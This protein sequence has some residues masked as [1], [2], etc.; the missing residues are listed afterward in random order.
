MTFFSTH[1]FRKFCLLAGAV[2]LSLYASG[3]GNL[4]F[5][6]LGTQDGLSHSWAKCVT[7][8]S[9]G[10]LWVGTINGLNR[11]D[12]RSFK[13]FKND[14]ASDLTLS[15]NFIQVV[16]EDSKGNL[17]VGTYSGGINKFDRTT[18]SFIHFRSMPK[19]SNSLSDDRI[20]AIYE[21]SNGHLWVGTEKG[22]DR[23]NYKGNHF[24][25]FYLNGEK[26]T[27]SLKGP[28]LAIGE[29]QSGAI[30]AGTDHGLYRIDLTS[31]TITEYNSQENGGLPVDHITS[32]YKD[33]TGQLW[34]GTL[35]GG[36]S[37]YLPAS[38]EFASYSF[39]EKSE[40]G[41][42]HNSVLCISGDHKGQLIIGTEG[43]GI[44]LMNIHSK[45]VQV[46]SPDPEDAFS[47]NSN[48]IHSLFYDSTTQITWVGT[49]HGGVNYFSKLSKPFIHY[50]AGKNELNNNNVLCIREANGRLYVGTDGGGVNIMD[51]RTKK[52]EYLRQD[53]TGNK[54]I[55]S[56]A[57]LSLLIDQ[58]SNLWI[59]T[60]NGGLDCLEP[61]GKMRHFYHNPDNHSSL[62]G[63]DISAIYEDRQ[64]WLWIGTMKGGLNLYNPT[65]GTFRRF[66]HEEGVPESLRDNFISYITEDNEGRLLI[67]TGKSLDIFDPEKEVFTDLGRKYH[68]NTGLPISTLVDSR[69]NTWMGSR[70]ALYFF[71]KEGAKVKIFTEKDGLPSSSITGILEDD[72]SNVWISTMRG[73][74]KCKGAVLSQEKLDIQVYTAEDGLQGNDFKDQACFKGTDGTLYFGG[75][76]GL[77][78]F[79]PKEIKENPIAPKV[80][81]TGFKLF[82]KDVEFGEGE[83]LAV[84]INEA[85]EI[86]LSYQH[87]VFTIEFSALNFILP[88]KNKYAYMMRGFEKDWNYVDFQ[89][90]ATYT[91]LNPGTYTFLVKAANNDGIWNETGASIQITISPP[92]WATNWFKTLIISAFVIGVVAVFRIRLYQLKTR[93]KILKRQVE[94]ATLEIQKV[95]QLLGE[96]NEE[97]Q[98][99]NSSLLD[100]NDQ[101]THQNEELEQQ[102]RKIQKL[103]SEIQELN[104]MKLRFFTNISHELRT[105]L[106]LIL[107]PLE[108]LISRSKDETGDHRELTVM[109][110][111]AVK[112]LQL[113]NQLLDF[114]KI[115]S[116]N[117]QL[118]A[119]KKDIVA[120]SREVFQSF[121]LLAQK[122]L[123]NYSFNANPPVCDL[124]FDQEKMEKI[125]TNVLSN[126]FKYTPDHGTISV[127]LKLFNTTG[128]SQS[129]VDIVIQDSGKGIPE[130][131]IEHIFDL[132]YQ[133]QNASTLEQAGSGIGLA[134]IKQYVDL[135]HGE[136]RVDSTVGIGTTLTVQFPVGSKHLLPSEIVEEVGEKYLSQYTTLELESSFS[137]LTESPQEEIEWHTREGETPLLLIVEDN[138]DIRRYIH[139][140]FGS[141]FRVEEAT[142]GL[143]ALS[144]A[145]EQI[146]DLIISDVMMP[147]LDGFAMCEQLKGDE[148]TSHIPV[149]LLTA[150]SGEEKQKQ[151]F[152][153][154]A[155]DYVTKPFNISILQQKIKNIIQTR[156]NLIEKFGRSTSLD[157]KKLTSNPADE[158]FLNK[159]IEVIQQN[160]INADFDVEAFSDQFSMSR[161]NLLRKIKSVTGLSVTEFIKNI[162]LKKSIQLLQDS[163]LNIS[164][165]AYAS[166]FSDPKYFSKCFREQFGKSPS[167]Y[168]AEHNR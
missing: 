26:S 124:W 13:V 153:A 90:T 141:S 45:S 34:V 1:Y 147:N 55:Q 156:R 102:S 46:F 40:S 114:R 77:N 150:Y 159:A 31:N 22:L 149:I 120:F 85:G 74:V 113:I 99:Q 48:S 166:G 110:R 92:W 95:N 72:E 49:Y 106:T 16:K 116:G 108:T 81:L 97:I 109:H 137:E 138:P 164:E 128:L 10:Y 11:Y 136:L 91:N 93:Q 69:K 142:D 33:E 101:L 82:N 63:R 2:G 35:G 107:G 146:P 66:Q 103:L 167:E 19:S 160:L 14:P 8:D 6:H 75:Q 87:N 30:W 65:T 41:L 165:V 37:L 131:Q 133:A 53:E 105:P 50:K 163:E 21:D 32:L 61:G 12:G 36:V 80:V 139:E 157:T 70:E 154:G 71:P 83:P 64:G 117:I 60:F 78:A 118:K 52:V 158:K 145:I 29:D 23:F 96:R 84:P 86:N 58:K 121:T 112:L 15:D 59:G 39:D 140:S 125:I 122:K 134:L 89:N 148:R 143:E 24:D 151:G 100:K 25:Y 43:G 47:L 17:W 135:H 127:K 123:I 3:Q 57:V 44:N 20:H 27:I 98:I 129:H 155:D 18:E 67:Q 5:Y 9:R 42:S 94:S 51:R 115:E 144:K 54:Q 88:E 56:D 68:I 28:V 79:D 168:L 161:R 132:Y 62:S 162:R 152:F 126:A 4:K 119:M 111:N 7:K 104:E 76:N 38:D 130:G 73:L